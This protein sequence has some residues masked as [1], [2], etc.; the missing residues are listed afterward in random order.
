MPTKGKRERWTDE[1]AL[2]RAREEAK[3]GKSPTTQAGE[4]VREEVEHIRHGKHGAR[5]TKQAIAIGLQKA[6]RAGV[7]GDVMWRLLDDARAAGNRTAYTYV[8]RENVASME[9]ERCLLEHPD[10][11]DAVVVGAPHERW[12]EAITGVVVVRPGAAVDEEQLLLHCRGRLAGFKVPKRIVFVS[13]F[14]RTG[15]GKVQKHVMRAQL[16]NLYST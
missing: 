11:A 10:V 12:G 3:E 1:E 4:F 16:S 14:A 2:K 7:M 8:E 13:E 5:S 15:T 9:V 6:R